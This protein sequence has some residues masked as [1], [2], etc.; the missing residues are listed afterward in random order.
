MRLSHFFGCGLAL[1]LAASAHAQYP[2][3]GTNPVHPRPPMPP[4][5][6]G[7]P[8]QPRTP[9]PQ[10]PGGTPAQPRSWPG[11]GSNSDRQPTALTNASGT[12]NALRP[13]AARR[14]FYPP[15]L[16]R[17]GDISQ[18]LGLVEPQIDRL[19]QFTE[20]MR[21]RYRDA[22]DQIGGLSTEEQ[23][24]SRESLDQQY[25]RDWM[26]GASTILGTDRFIR[27]QQ[28]DVQRSG[29]SALADPALQ[30]WLNLTQK[31][32]SDL[33]PSI[34]WSLQ[35][36][37]EIRRL[38][39]TDIDRARQLYRDYQRQSEDLLNRFLTPEQQTTWRKGGRRLWHPI[40]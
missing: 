24:L 8:A 23:L 2:V 11:V 28:L 12:Q 15:A 35:Q 10:T 26:N 22:Y 36:R 31:Q 37:Q 21:N 9:Q 34:L 20:E 3:P 30:N 38:A 39:A 1:V 16:Y 18:S 32:R 7:T 29:I 14:Y 6:G 4:T 5:P 17:F 25:T 40:P 33:S 19:N 27:Y 13:F